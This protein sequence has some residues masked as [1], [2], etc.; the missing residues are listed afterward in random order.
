MI[1]VINLLKPPGMSSNNAVVDIRR[2]LKIKKVG[3]MGTLDPGAAGV[4]PVCVGKATRLFPYLVNKDKEYIFEIQFGETTDTL[5]AYGK[6][7]ADCNC[8]ISISMLEAILPKFLGAQWQTPPMY[9]ALKVEGRKMYELARKGQEIERSEKRRQIQIDELECI[10]QTGKNRFLLRTVCSRG[11]YIRTLCEDIAEELACCGYMS[12]LLRSRV[13]QFDLQK[14]WSMDELRSKVERD[15]FDFFED[16]EQV[17]KNYQRVQVPSALYRILRNGVPLDIQAP[18]ENCEGRSYS[19]FC[20][21][22]FF[23]LGSWHGDLLKI[24]C[25]L[26]E[27]S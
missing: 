19:I 3:H 15:E 2:L 14:S 4:L 26:H 24:D 1:G 10:E 13:G 5:D 11:T 7:M 8:D 17:L 16:F 9:S 25:F 23:G 18:A 22:E 12:F 6:K 20:R 27:T 21:D